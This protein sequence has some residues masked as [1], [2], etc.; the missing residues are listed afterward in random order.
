M[1]QQKRWQHDDPEIKN[2]MD[3][4]SIRHGQYSLGEYAI[5][6]KSTT[7]DN[8]VTITNTA[9]YAEAVEFGW[10]ETKHI[11]SVW[12]MATAPG[13]HVFQNVLTFLKTTNYDLLNDPDHYIQAAELRLDFINNIFHFTKD[14]K[15]MVLMIKEGRYKAH[16]STVNST[17]LSRLDEYT[18]SYHKK[19]GQLNQH[20]QSIYH[21]DFRWFL[22]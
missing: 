7:I 21:A 22:G 11:P 17:Y 4:G 9:K 14:G 6:F 8:K 2:R 18:R 3:I 13:Y 15:D 19:Y 5:S 20:R 16:S 12:E 10:Q 1:Q